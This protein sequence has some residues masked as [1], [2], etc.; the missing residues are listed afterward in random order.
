M[1]T[2]AVFNNPV[3]SALRSLVLLVEAYPATLDLQKLVY[4]DYLLVHS[5]DAGGPESLH[6]PT[7]QRDGEVAV[8]RDLIE[9]GLHL[10]LMRGLVER[11][12]TNNGFEYAALDAAGSIIASLST[13]YSL[14]LR[15]RAAWVTQTFA[16][17]DITT[18]N[19]F[20]NEHIGRWGEEFTLIS[21]GWEDGA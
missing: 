7:P 6:P 14:L 2:D 11:R 16:A 13:E 20:F 12:A 17:R 19:A 9:Q 8:R 10:L 4:L 1:N 5:A 18:L 3:E 15:A 21:P